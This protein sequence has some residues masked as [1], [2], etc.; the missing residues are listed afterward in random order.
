MTLRVTISVRTVEEINQVLQ[1]VPRSSSKTCFTIACSSSPK[2]LSLFLVFWFHCVI[3]HRIS[4]VDVLYD[5]TALSGPRFPN[6]RGFAITLR[7][8]ILIRTPPD[9]RTSH[10]S[11]L[12][13]TTHNTHKRQTTMSTA[14][15]QLAFS[16][17]KPLSTHALNRAAVALGPLW[18]L[19]T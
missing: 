11:G 19:F 7:H 4:C 13:V 12:Y 18:M 2:D 9:E 14:G 10:R 5:V 8:T 1:K 6:Y 15:F 3:F 16:A 17:S